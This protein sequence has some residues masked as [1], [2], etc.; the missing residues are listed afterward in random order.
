MRL[1]PDGNLAPDAV[2]E[3]YLQTAAVETS[4]RFA[5]DLNQKWVA[6]Q[7]NE[8]GHSDVYVRSFRDKGEK[9]KVSDQGGSFPVWG[10]GGRELFYVAPD[11]KLM[12]VDITFSKSSGSG[13]YGSRG[14][15][16]FLRGITR[17]PLLLTP[18]MVSDSW[19]YLLWR[20]TGRC[21][22]R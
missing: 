21:N 19:F 1:A 14:V 7:S 5:P 11:N 8:L 22:C 6:Y 9:V 13:V 4:A 17:L 16:G 2:P 18:S 20:P 15:P 12:A 10:P 3:P